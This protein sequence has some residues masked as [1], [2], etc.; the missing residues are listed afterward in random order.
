MS[1]RATASLKILLVG[2][3][4]MGRAL[5][6]GWLAHGMLSRAVV[7]EPDAAKVPASAQLAAVPDAKAIPQDFHPDI[8]VFA[9]K[10]QN[11]PGMIAEYARFTSPSAIFLSIA[12]GK[13]LG[14]F[15]RALGDKAKIVRAMPNSPASIHAAITVACPNAHITGDDRHKTGHLLQAIGDVLWVE[16]ENL[17]NPVTA[18][19]G[20]GPAYVF[21]MIEAM[22]AS[23]EKLGLPRPMADKLARATIYGSGLLARK[24]AS[25]PAEKLRH[26]V[27]SPGGTT[28]AALDTLL[29]A[30]TGL[31]ALM[32]RAMTAATHR[33]KE[34][35]D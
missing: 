23:G 25:V 8:I 10:P 7:V 27:T 14:F 17:I 4:N 2:C 11:L 28:A 31:P 21:L 34:L 12:A 35:E 5:L 1:P 26:N 6:D 22:A 16:D 15:G 29:D 3:G 9:V 18:L 19:S 33:A 32:D 13:T 24:E 20:S 30:Q